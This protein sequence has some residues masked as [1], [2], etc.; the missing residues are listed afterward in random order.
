[1][2]FEGVRRLRQ[3]DGE[4]LVAVQLA[5][6]PNE[7]LAEVGVDPPIA[8]LVRVR[9]GA[10]RDPASQARVVELRLH[11][12]QA[13]LDV[14][15]A[16]PVRHLGEGQAEELVVAGE[17][18]GPMLAAVPLDAPLEGA[19]RNA[20]HQLCKHGASDRHWPVL[21]SGWQAATLGPSLRVGVNRYQSIV[22]RISP[23]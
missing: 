4:G 14:A 19:A 8:R 9:E 11:G 7:E 3:L 20:V 17:R 23:H 21:S 22:A 16:L 12:A 5:G 10:S 1:M 13:G 2:I 15:K 6:P 18:M